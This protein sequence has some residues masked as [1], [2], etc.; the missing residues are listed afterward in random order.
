MMKGHAQYRRAG[1]SAKARRVGGDM[2]VHAG[3]GRPFPSRVSGHSWSDK[4]R[5]DQADTSAQ[6]GPTY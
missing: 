4:R 1:C 2:V 6:A 3:E 5:E